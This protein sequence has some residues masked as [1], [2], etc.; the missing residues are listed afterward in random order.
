MGRSGP[1]NR[2]QVLGSVLGE[3]RIIFK[4]AKEENAPLGSSTVLATDNKNGSDGL[5]AVL[6]LLDAGEECFPFL[7]EMFTFAEERDW[8]RDARFVSQM[9]GVPR[10]EARGNSNMQLA[11]VFTLENA[12]NRMSRETL[13]R[14]GVGEEARKALETYRAYRDER[15]EALR[16]DCVTDECRDRT[17]EQW[18]NISSRFFAN[19]PDFPFKDPMEATVCTARA[20]LG[21]A[22]DPVGT[23]MIA[24]E[25]AAGSV[26]K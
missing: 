10:R 2:D 23:R 25:R 7:L 1:A 20:Y 9:T 13:Q 15:I 4:R 18:D 11:L 24:R 3:L 6:C 19:T 12:L 16:K 8:V 17:T 22:L 26:P 5:V 14:E 21:L